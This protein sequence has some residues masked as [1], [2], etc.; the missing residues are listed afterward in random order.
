MR[1]T[2]GRK[3]SETPNETNLDI[4][5]SIATHFRERT[6]LDF[7]TCFNLETTVNF[8][9]F[10]KNF[11]FLHANCSRYMRRNALCL[12][13][14]CRTLWV[15]RNVRKP[16]V[17]LFLGMGRIESIS[18]CRKVADASPGNNTCGHVVVFF[19]FS[20]LSQSRTEHHLVHL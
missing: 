12:R 13:H 1:A 19:C 17:R 16:A 3:C 4:C 10:H 6:V 15:S 14:M 7:I 5:N 8:C 2:D 9:S 11:N 18:N 20:V